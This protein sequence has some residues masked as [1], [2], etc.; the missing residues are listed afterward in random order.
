[1]FTAVTAATMTPTNIVGGGTAVTA[2]AGAAGNLGGGTTAAAV[3]LTNSHDTAGNLSF[4]TTAAPAASSAIV[5]VTFATPYAT[6]PHVVISP[7]N[8]A[9]AT[10]DGVAGKQVF[11]TSTVNGFTINSN[12]T[13][14][15][16]ATTYAWNYICIG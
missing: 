3:T 10:I 14:L 15:T 9:T 11:V 6:A 16:T 8:A 1:M 7:T 4:T 12:T 13:A 5:T 2:A